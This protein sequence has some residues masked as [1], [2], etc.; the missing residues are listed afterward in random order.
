MIKKEMRVEPKT[1]PIKSLP[2][3]NKKVIGKS[4]VT[5]PDAG[6]STSGC[7]VRG[8]LGEIARACGEEDLRR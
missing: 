4:S 8:T 6:C 7:K 3:L 1:G 5:A 2:V